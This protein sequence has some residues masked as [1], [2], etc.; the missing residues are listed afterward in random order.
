LDD[1]KGPFLEQSEV[2][3]WH[4]LRAVSLTRDAPF[5][6][7]LLATVAIALAL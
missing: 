4:S 7:I 3:V 2:V 6:L 5:R 1:A